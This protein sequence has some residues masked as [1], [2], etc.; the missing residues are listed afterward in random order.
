M[1][2]GGRKYIIFVGSR[3]LRGLPLSNARQVMCPY[4]SGLKA[5]DYLELAPS[6]AF[7]SEIVREWLK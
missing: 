4:R 3:S 7:E 1:N 2:I 6:L 5:T